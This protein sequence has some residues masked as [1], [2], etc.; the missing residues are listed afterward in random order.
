MQAL[1]PLSEKASTIRDL[2]EQLG[3]IPP[4]RVRMRP[5]PGTATEQDVIDADAHEDR[6]CELVDGV[7]V[8]KAMGFRE[9]M[10]AI[11]IASVLRAFVTPRKLGLVSGADGMMRVLPGLVRIP[12]VAFISWKHLPGGRVPKE[13]VPAL[14]P[15]LAVEV[16]SA[17]NTA[18]EMSRKRREFFEAGTGLIWEVDL[19]SRAISV[20]TSE[21]TFEVFAEGQMVT[22][23]HVLPGFSM[24]IGALFS[25]LDAL[26]EI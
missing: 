5:P 7:L 3:G 18:A 19:K 21:T 13:P 11:A 4:E 2:L 24:D 10:I 14:A 12:D 9:S 16:L 8:E 1:A 6:I 25:E 20:Y 26:P 17:G 15:D 22:G 23:G